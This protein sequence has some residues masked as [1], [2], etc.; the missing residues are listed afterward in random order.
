MARPVRTQPREDDKAAA[1]FAA[2]DIALARGD[3][4]AAAR[5]QAELARLGWD[6]KQRRPWHTPEREGV[7]HA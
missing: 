3:Y 4:A 1:H 5:A 6:I 2:L 7:V